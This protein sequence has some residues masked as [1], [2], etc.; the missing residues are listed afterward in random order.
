VPAPHPEPCWFL[1]S[2]EGFPDQK[3]FQWPASLI[4]DGV[5]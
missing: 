4:S 3:R 1:S 5:G 2:P